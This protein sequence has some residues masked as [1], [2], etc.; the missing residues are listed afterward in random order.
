[1]VAED[2][3]KATFTLNTG[4][5]IPAIGLGTWQ[6]RTDEGK[7]A[8]SLA[9][10]LGYRHIDTSLNHSAAAYDNETE[11]GQGIRDSGVPRSEIFLTTKLNNSDH[12]RVREALND[13]LTKLGV[14]YVDLYLVH[15]PISVDISD[16]T[17]IYED[18]DFVKTWEEVQKLPETGLVRAVGVSNF[19]IRH[20][21]KLLA[22]PTT[23]VVPAVNQIE[24]HPYY[25]SPKLVEY[26]K[27]KGIH[28]S[29]YA[30]LG[31]GGAWV[32][33][34]ESVIFKDPTIV[35][36]AE[37]Y[38]K[39]VGQILLAWGIQK[40]RSVLPK[41]TN[42][43]RIQENFGGLSGWRLEEGDV[44]RISKIDVRQKVYQAGWLPVTAFLP[45]DEE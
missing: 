44:E 35:E 40:G 33:G 24:L 8:V 12:K 16:P 29:G 45:G 15:W 11:I 20:L 7:K 17:K 26:S 34:G 27:S 4:A 10:K 5:K 38:G 19:S 25:Q 6:T 30:P 31:A 22:A 23:K 37:K 42:E 36:I 18:W 21:E 32:S 39:K 3:T 41:S 14:D 9:L 2:F 1:M 28:V 43:G 13:S